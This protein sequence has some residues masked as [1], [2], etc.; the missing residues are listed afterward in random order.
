M[1]FGDAT[2]VIELAHLRE[3]VRTNMLLGYKI[4]GV[5]EVMGSQAS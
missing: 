3:H 4:Q 1:L 5:A 2:E